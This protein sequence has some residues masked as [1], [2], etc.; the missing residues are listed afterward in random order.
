MLAAPNSREASTMS[1]GEGSRFEFYSAQYAR[2]GS[3]LAGEIRQEVYGTDLGQQG[4]RTLEE[5]KLIVEL[6]ADRPSSRFV[7]VACGS[8][9]PSLA[10]LSAV[11]GCSVTGIDLEEAAVA[12]AKQ[13]AAA[14]GL[15]ERATFIAADC[16]RPLPLDGGAHDVVVCIDA[17]SHLRH[18]AAVLVDWFHLLRPGGR[19]MFTDPAVLTGAVSR[20]EFDVRASQGYF[21]LVAA[22]FNEDALTAAGF[23]LLR[24]DDTSSATADIAERTRAAR[25]RRRAALEETEGA[26]WFAK[27]QAF[28]AMTAELAATGRLSRLRYHAEK[29]S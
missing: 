20:D 5:Q 25:E 11:D 22:G 9:G 16:G 1:A 7:D 17:I 3:A 29:P 12:E 18:R 2:F 26:D 10:V 21:A 24:T 15:S 19:L 4:W 27:R 6:V 8:G 23:R 28:L 14:A 13:R